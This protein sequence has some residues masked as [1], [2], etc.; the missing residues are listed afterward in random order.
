MTYEEARA[1]LPNASFYYWDITAKELMEC[2]YAKQLALVGEGVLLGT[3]V[4]Y[5]ELSAKAI[6]P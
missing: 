1:I 6:Y 5:V 2:P 3:V 4:E